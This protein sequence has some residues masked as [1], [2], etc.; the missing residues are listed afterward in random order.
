MYC[1]Q[2]IK[3]VYTRVIIVLPLLF[4]LFH[5]SSFLLFVFFNKRIKM[6]SQTNVSKSKTNKV[7]KIQSGKSL[8][9]KIVHY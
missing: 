5:S 3:K 4:D 2:Y 1:V 6:K 7:T 8:T 9:A